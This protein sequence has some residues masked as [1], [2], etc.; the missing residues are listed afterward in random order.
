[1]ELVDLARYRLGESIGEGAD[2]QVFGATEVET[3]HQ[4]VLKRPHPTLVVRGQHRDIEEQTLRMSELRAS[5]GAELPH[6]TRLFGVSPEAD[7]DAFFGDSL[8]N[9]YTVTVEERARGVP[10]VGS[11]VDGLMGHPIGLPQ[12]LF[13]LYP[14][15]TGPERT[16]APVV[17]D[18]LSVVD[19][20]YQ[21]GVLLTD[22]RP[23][24]IFY[25]PGNSE[26]TIV[27]LESVQPV[28]GGSSR[29]PRTDVHDLFLDLFRWYS[30]PYDPPGNPQQWGRAD[31]L[32]LPPAFD[33]AVATLTGLYESVRHTPERDGAQSILRRIAD[34]GYGGVGEFADDFGR[35]L[36]LKAAR[37]QRDDGASEVWQEA[38]SM[39]ERPYWTRY[40]FDAETELAGY[41]R[42]G[43]ASL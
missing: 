15:A 13:C 18:V 9:E 26:V 32:P 12:N 2:R 1:M 27:D 37:L 5:L 40:L 21:A 39:L 30:A 35:F 24:N 34:R 23:Q 20:C 42:P 10:L 22:L 4:V 41:R 7:H 3:G 36:A 43:R 28:A 29:R 25:A 38:L 19:R 17:L 16:A 14:L 6:V 33:A 31:E 8:G 11:V